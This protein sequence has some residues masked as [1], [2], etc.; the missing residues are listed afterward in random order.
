MRVASFFSAKHSL[1]EHSHGLSHVRFFA[2]DSDEVN[3]STVIDQL[4]FQ[5]S[6]SQH[7]V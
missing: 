4:V 5:D 7:D 6:I 3:G 2:N 1:E